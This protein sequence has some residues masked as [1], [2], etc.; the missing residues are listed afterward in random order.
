MSSLAR[1]YEKAIAQSQFE[2]WLNNNLD[3]CRRIIYKVIS[4]RG[5]INVQVGEDVDDI[6]NEAIIKIYNAGIK[7]IILDEEGKI[8]TRQLRSLISIAATSIMSDRLKAY[9][10]RANYC[11]MQYKVSLDSSEK[12]MTSSTQSQEDFEDT[13]AIAQAIKKTVKHNQFQRKY[14]IMRYIKGYTRERISRAMSLPVISLTNLDEKLFT[15]IRR[16]LNVDA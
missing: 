15:E 7:Y 1:E 9:R 12:Y 11:S 8:S 16:K 4:Q 13:F 6:L 10:V 5:F 3:L 2:D 14:F